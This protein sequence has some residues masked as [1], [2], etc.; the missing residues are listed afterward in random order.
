MYVKLHVNKDKY[1]SMKNL[2]IFLLLDL[3]LIY[4]N[5]FQYLIDFVINCFKKAYSN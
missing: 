5:N 1:F 4:L 3:L 2:C